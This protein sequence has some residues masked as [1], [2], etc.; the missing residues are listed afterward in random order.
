[1]TSREELIKFQDAINRMLEHLSVFEQEN[2][3]TTDEREALI[4]AVQ[5]VTWN[6]S[7]YPENVQPHILGQNVVP[8]TVKIADAVQAAGFRRSEVPERCGS[9]E[10]DQ[11]GTAARCVLSNRHKGACAYQRVVEPQA[12]PTD[13]QVAA[14]R[15]A[16]R[17]TWGGDDDKMR[18]ARREGRRIVSD[19]RIQFPEP[20]RVVIS[21]DGHFVEVRALA[22]ALVSAGESLRALLPAAEKG[23]RDAN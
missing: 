11:Y 19:H 1:M 15:K 14:A 16:Y 13:A 17:Q 9:F 10:N 21:I 18:A 12:E 22:D 2:T 8:L 5:A 3:P 6:A 4:T 7:N 23:D 20:G